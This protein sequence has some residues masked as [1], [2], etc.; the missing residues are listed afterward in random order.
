MNLHYQAPKHV[1]VPHVE[2]NLYSTNKYSCFR[3]V[4]T[5]FTL[6]IVMCSLRCC[7]Y[8]GSV[9]PDSAAEQVFFP[10]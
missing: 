2:N 4:H 6:V 3:R 1:V 10:L 5:D 8:S 9:Y 7:L